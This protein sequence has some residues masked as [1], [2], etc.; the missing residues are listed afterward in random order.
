[1]SVTRSGDPIAQLSDHPHRRYNPLLDEW[2]LVSAG[3]TQRPWQGTE[4]RRLASTRHGLRPRRATSVPG[5]RRAN[6]AVTP[7]TTQTFVFTNDFAA[8]RPDSPD[9][10]LA[11]GL[12]RA[13]VEA[14]TCRVLCFSRR[15]DL[16]LARDGPAAL[17]ARSSTS[18]PTRPPSSASSSNGSRCSKTGARPWVRPTRI[19][20]ARSG[21]GARCPHVAAREDRTQLAHLRGHG[22]PLL[23]DYIAQEAGGPQDRVRRCRLVGVGPVLGRRGR[24]RRCWSRSSRRS[25]CPIWTMHGAIRWPPQ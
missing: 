1:M 14:G 20:T 16:T 2:L 10:R 11:E 7:T 8:L 5:N 6:G 18:G 9:R 24:T 19:P 25:G 15:H 22:E 12:L 23:L 21:P 17:S 3:R 13:E 4:G